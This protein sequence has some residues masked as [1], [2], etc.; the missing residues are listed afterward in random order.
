MYGALV[1]EAAP[2]SRFSFLHAENSRTAAAIIG[3]TALANNG[4]Y[5]AYRCSGGKYNSANI[6][7]LKKARE[8][9]VTASAEYREASDSETFPSN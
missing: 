9:I 3:M 1:Y 6:P 5:T 7:G 8:A 2:A 4:A